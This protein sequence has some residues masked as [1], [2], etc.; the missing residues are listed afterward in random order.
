[1]DRGAGALVDACARAQR[2]E[3]LDALAGAAVA[4]AV[5]EPGRAPEVGDAAVVLLD[6]AEEAQPAEHALA[7][8]ARIERAVVQQ[9]VEDRHQGGAGV[10][11][12]SG[13]QGTSA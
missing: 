7:A 10:R 3:G 12:E 9:A 4:L 2:A 11:S 8:E 13:V 1:R 6:H 5:G